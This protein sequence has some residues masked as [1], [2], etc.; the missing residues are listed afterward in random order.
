MIVR[1][2]L[3]RFGDLAQ[4][5]MQL[6]FLKFGRNDEQQADDLGLRYMTRQDYDPR[7][8]VEVFSVLDRLGQTSGEGRLPAW[9]STHPAP[10]NRAQRIQSEIQ[11]QKLAGT[12]VEV[13]GYL[14]RVDGMVFG[15]NPREGFFEGAAFFHPELRFQIQFP[16]GW[17]GQNQKQA[18]GAVS[19]QDDAIVVMTL[20]PGT[21]ADQAANEFLRQQGL[22]PAG[23]ERT[24]VH[25]LPAVTGIFEAVADQTPIAG[26][27]A[28]V[29]HG[30]KVYRVLGYTPSVRWGNYDRVFAESL[31]S[32]APLADRRYLDVQPRRVKVVPVAQPMTVEELGRRHGATVSTDVLALINHVAPG[33]SLPA[34]QPA[35]VVIGGRL[36]NEDRR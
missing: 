4:A 14:R 6:M 16:R 31:A 28:F 3:A 35:K 32:F 1:P 13:P 36:P 5:G 9:L 23:A 10:A 26:R 7:E 30:E 21:S 29:E 11:A 22:R 27:V 24:T 12:R 17:R 18:V 15:E 25:G 8:M 33:A 34:G 20:V 19:P 2:E